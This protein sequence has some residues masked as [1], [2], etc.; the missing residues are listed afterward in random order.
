LRYQSNVSQR[1]R[2][3]CLDLIIDPLVVQSRRN[4]MIGMNPITTKNN[5]V[6]TFTSMMK[7]IVASD[8][9]PIVSS[10]EM[11]P[12]TSIGLPRMY[13][14]FRYWLNSSGFSNTASLGP[15]HI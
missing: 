9:L 14:V 2:M 12:L 6:V 11:T 5:T 15:R 4:T 10:I 3:N 1:V 13:N 7:N 8:F